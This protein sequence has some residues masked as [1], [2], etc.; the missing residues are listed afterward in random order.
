MSRW[1]KDDDTVFIVSVDEGKDF[2]CVDSDKAAEDSVMM[3]W[4]GHRLWYHAGNHAQ[5]IVLILNSRW[6]NLHKK[7]GQQFYNKRER[8][9]VNYSKKLEQENYRKERWEEKLLVFEIRVIVQE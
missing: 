5:S 4:S 3:Q 1:R 2:F 7:G 6:K 9:T 8:N